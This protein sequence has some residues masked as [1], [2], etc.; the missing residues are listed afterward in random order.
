MSTAFERIAV[1]EPRVL[2]SHAFTA[3]EIKRFA[4]AYDPQRFHMDEEEA[5]ASTFGAL[6]ASGWHTA[7]AMMRLLV[8]SIAREAEAARARNEAPPRYGPSPGFDNLKWLRPV[9]AGDTVTYT[10]TVTAKRPSRSRPG[11]GIVTSDVAGANQKGEP[12]FAVTTQVFVRTDD[13]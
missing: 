3:E 11:W 12:V 13:A 4:A 8:G 7:S 5:K 1:G 6:A 9:Y 10:T 2:G